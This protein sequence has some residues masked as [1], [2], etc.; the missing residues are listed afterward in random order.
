MR[1]G[2]LIAG[3]L[4]LG[5]G[6]AIWNSLN[7]GGHSMTPPNTTQTASGDPIVN[8]QLP[9]SLST[10]AALGEKFFNV[11]CSVCHGVNAEGINGTAPPLIHKIYEPS[12]HGDEAFYRATLIG[13]E[14]H[15][16]RF[17]NMPPV[18]GVT[19]ADIKP[20]ITYIR[21]VQRANGIK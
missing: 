19:R 6:A 11:K 17:G 12:H 16:W 5:A 8:V 3:V 15:H 1:F 13:V 18:Q 9:T 20:I 21:E 7:S 2:F 14:A 4:V 10:E